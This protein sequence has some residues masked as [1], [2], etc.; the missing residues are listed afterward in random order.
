MRIFL[1]V[2]IEPTTARPLAPKYPHL[3]HMQHTLHS[4][5]PPNPN[6]SEHQLKG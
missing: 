3:S 5:I 6:L 2:I 4:N 1:G